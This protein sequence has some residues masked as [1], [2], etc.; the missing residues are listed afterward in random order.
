MTTEV[1]MPL[2]SDDDRAAIDEAAAAGTCHPPSGRPEPGSIGG[3]PPPRPRAPCRAR[4]PLD[5]PLASV[6][7]LDAPEAHTHL[8][9]LAGAS[10]PST[11]WWSAFHQVPMSSVKT[12]KA[13]SIGASTVTDVRTDVSSTR[14]VMRSPWQLPRTRPAIDSKTCRGR[15]ATLAAPLGRTDRSAGCPRRGLRRAPPA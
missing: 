6:Q 5:L 2:A 4:L 13:C 7:H 9:M 12:L 14:T 15:R 11:R 3:A 10:K 1:G 8:R